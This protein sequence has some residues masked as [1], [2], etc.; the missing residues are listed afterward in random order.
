MSDHELPNTAQLTSWAM[1]IRAEDGAQQ[2]VLYDEIVGVELDDSEVAQLWLSMVHYQRAAQAAVTALVTELGKRLEAL[3]TGIEVGDEWIMYTPS[4]SS[5]I[6]DAAGFWQWI[7]DNPEYLEPAFNPNTIRKTGIPSSVFD[8][9][10]EVVEA[11]KATVSSIPLH[12]LE[13]N[14]QRDLREGEVRASDE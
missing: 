8:T 11:P 3:G 5:R 2:P 9:F 13:R 6:A 10:F 12:V 1:A 4:K 7:K 14:R